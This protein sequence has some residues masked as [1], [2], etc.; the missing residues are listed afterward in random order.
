M[1]L[2]L[3]EPPHADADRRRR[4]VGRSAPAIGVLIE[5]WLFFAEAEHVVMVYYRGGSGV[6][7][8]A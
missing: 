3:I 8:I 6:T 5:R 7:L 4:A 2:L 1:L